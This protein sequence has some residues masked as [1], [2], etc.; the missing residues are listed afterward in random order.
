MQQR[1]SNLNGPV[2]ISPWLQHLRLANGLS[3]WKQGGVGLRDNENNGLTERKPD[4]EFAQVWEGCV[5]DQCVES[6]VTEKGV[7]VFQQLH[8]SPSALVSYTVTVKHNIK[9]KS[10]DHDTD[11]EE[12]MRATREE[13]RDVS[14]DEHKEKFGRRGSRP[15]L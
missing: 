13:M 6:E 15:N 10:G 5:K 11:R 14:E 12:D 2:S 7:F 1:Y 4:G 8:E 9:E 3:G